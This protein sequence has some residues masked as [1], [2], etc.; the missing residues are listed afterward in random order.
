MS[1]RVIAAPDVLMKLRRK[2]SSL[3]FVTLKV[4]IGSRSISPDGASVNTYAS[5]YARSPMPDLKISH[6]DSR[7]SDNQI[8]SESRN[9]INSPLESSFHCFGPPMDPVHADAE[10]TLQFVPHSSRTSRRLGEFRQSL[11]HS[12]LSIPNVYRSALLRSPMP[13]L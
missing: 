4:A 3:G 5:E 6:K 10:S 11:R 12:L 8:S 9:A 1:L 2:R 7:C 13:L